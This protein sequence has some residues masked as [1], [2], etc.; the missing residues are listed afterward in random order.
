MTGIDSVAAA[1]LA[2]R[3][4]SLLTG[5]VSAPA[6]GGATSQVGTPGTGTASTPS[7]G[8]PPAAPPASTQTALSDVGRVLD[9]ISRAGGDSTPAIAGRVPLLADPTV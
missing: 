4:D 2:S 6:G 5:T 1:L 3:L 8:S 9:A 7:A